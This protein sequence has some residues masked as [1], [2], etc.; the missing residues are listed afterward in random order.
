MDIKQATTN[1]EQNGQDELLWDVLWKPLNF[2]RNVRESFKLDQPQI[3]IIAV[4]NSVVIGA[5]VAN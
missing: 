1:K 3:D 5:L 2:K 4:D